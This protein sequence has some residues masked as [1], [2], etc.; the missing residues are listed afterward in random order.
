MILENAGAGTG[1][2]VIDLCSG[3]VQRGWRVVVAY[4]EGRLETSFRA[5]LEQISDLQYV[6]I[7]MR[8][9]PGPWD[10]IAV[11]RLWKYVKTAGPFALIHG[12]SSKGGALARLVGYLT[13]IPVFYTP[14]AL[15]T[16]DPTLSVG[17]R[18]LFEWMERTLSRLTRVVFCVSSDEQ[19]HARSI[20]IPEQKLRTVPNGIRALP[21]PDRHRL[22][23]TLG[24]NEKQVCLGFV[25]RLSHQKAV[26]GLLEAFSR[27]ANQAP[28]AHLAIVGE[29]NEM[30]SLQALS[31]QL[32]LEEQVTW[33]GHADG[34]AMM[35]AFDI[36]VL[37]SLYE[38]FPYVL[39][40]AAAR[41][42]PIVMTNVGG[43]EEMAERAGARTV[44][45]ADTEA[46]AAALLESIRD[47]QWRAEASE[48]ARLAS[49]YFSAERMVDDIEAI[50][51]DDS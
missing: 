22:R 41:E 7:P 14:H 32:G 45:I 15:V 42:L 44:A 5:E 34:A 39:L 28:E 12:H 17:K 9:D 47:P 50:Y 51:L 1:R 11:Y 6:T 20:G 13:R 29:G 43:A 16:L 38:G 27:V 3:L 8:R 48:C 46:L 26:D 25:G 21:A 31:A 19:E 2:H 23:E 37:S 36:L 33:V 49:A 30:R 18:W 10:L 4:S 35:A 24:L 40:E